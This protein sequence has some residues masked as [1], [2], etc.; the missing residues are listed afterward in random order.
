MFKNVGLQRRHRPTIQLSVISKTSTGTKEICY[1]QVL[2]S[3]AEA[4]LLHVVT[5]IVGGW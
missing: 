2:E 3:L 4:G 5:V 1:C